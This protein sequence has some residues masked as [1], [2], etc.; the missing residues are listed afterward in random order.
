MLLCK[1]YGFAECWDSLHP[2]FLV[3]V[4]ALFSISCAVY[5]RIL[6]KRIQEFEEGSN[7]AFKEFERTL[8]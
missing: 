4:F 5:T 3:F 1:G 6:C 8:R 2:L 7:K